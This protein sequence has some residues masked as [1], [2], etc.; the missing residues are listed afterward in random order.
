MSL[1]MHFR[2]IQRRLE[3]VLRDQTT[4]TDREAGDPQQGPTEQISIQQQETELDSLQEPEDVDV[5]R[6]SVDPQKEENG[7]QQGTP[8]IEQSLQAP[9]DDCPSYIEYYKE[10]CLDWLGVPAQENL[11]DAFEVMYLSILFFKLCGLRSSIL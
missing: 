5:P 6:G 10:F 2:R 7:P 9:D 8:D 11:M 3:E 1:C 4:C